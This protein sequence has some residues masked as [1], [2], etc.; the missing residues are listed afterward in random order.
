MRNRMSIHSRSFLLLMLCS[1]ALLPSG[2]GRSEQVEVQADNPPPSASPSTKPTSIFPT[3]VPTTEEWPATRPPGVRL[4]PVATASPHFKILD[5][6]ATLAAS[7]EQ[8]RVARITVE[9][10]TPSSPP[11]PVPF[12]TPAPIDLPLGID[13]YGPGALHGCSC[14]FNN[15]W[16]GMANN[17]YIDVYA[18]AGGLDYYHPEQGILMVGT[19][20]PILSDN[21]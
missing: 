4:S 21:F 18:G 13:D 15:H 3:A 19:Y 7:N 20:T 10:L 1:F 2:C 14:R 16:R 6:K 11:I 8:T 12:V 5:A 9:A 17:H